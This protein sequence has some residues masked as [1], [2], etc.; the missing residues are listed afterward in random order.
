MTTLEELADEIIE[1]DLLIFGGGRAGT[2]AAIRAKEK[3]NVDVTLVEKANMERSGDAISGFDQ[4]GPM[5]HPAFNSISAEDYG[6]RRAN[7][8]DGMVS[9][10]LGIL[11]AKIAMKPLAVLEDIGVKVREEDGT[12]K[13]CP[14]SP[15]SGPH[16]RDTSKES[17][18]ILF[19]GADLKPKLAAEVIKRGVRVYNRTMLTS[20]ITR[21]GSVVGAT[22]VNVRDGK[23]F[24]FKSKFVLL[25]T[26][27]MESRLKQANPY[28]NFPEYLFMHMHFPPSA[29]GGHAAAYRAGAKLINME[30]NHHRH[31][32]LGRN[33]GPQGGNV[34]KLVNSKGENLLVKYA[35]RKEKSGGISRMQLPF[36]PDISQP[37]IEREVI[38]LLT[39]G[40]PEGPAEQR[41]SFSSANETPK[42]LRP[43]QERGGIRSAPFEI[44]SYV[45]GIPRN[46]SG[47]MF[48]EQG[49]TSLKGLFA[50]G[51]IVGGLSLFG[52]G[53]PLGWG[54]KIGDYL[55]ELAPQTEKPVFD[56][57]QIQQ[58]EAERQRVF[59]PMGRKDGVNP[60]QVE[61]LV[62]K[63]LTNYNGI[64]KTEP[65]LKRCLEHLQAINER[66]VPALVANNPHE[67]MRAIEV[68]DIIE[69]G[70][71]HTRAGLLRT[72]SRYIPAHYRM[73]YPE[74]DDEKWLN[75]CI[76]LYKA[77][78]EMRH[79]IET[80]D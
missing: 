24:V 76:A 78:G 50:A 10:K 38:M 45:Q 13:V 28:D 41:A 7:D 40:I 57:D 37:E 34:G 39:E 26:G 19:R 43:K 17:D 22:A 33:P 79:S 59:A 8:L 67:L 12:F 44:F 53:G 51:D 63:I 21:D 65:K 9:T 80:L 31:A 55:R 62:R 16:T 42:D 47:V 56:N 35:D 66:L 11:T 5:I 20:L 73:D 6:R 36:L 18:M 60:L 68:Q 30:L 52:S 70:E 3:G 72:E 69:I 1:T 27:S 77:D 23:F 2:M 48:D 32:G 61:D 54:Y 75:K 58:V 14:F 46:V 74:Q 4:Y 64:R 29:G 71:M 15:L 49:E 25:A